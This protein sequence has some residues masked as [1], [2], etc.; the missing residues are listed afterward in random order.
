VEI[1]RLDENGHPLPVQRESI[2]ADTLALGYGF[3][4]ATQL[5]R[6]LGCEHEFAP[7]RGGWIPVRDA[8]MQ[9]TLPGVFAVGDGAGIGGV[10]LARLEGQKAGMQ[11]AHQLGHIDGQAL[12]SLASELRPRLKRE[13]RFADL[14]GD[15]FT[16]GPGLY[17]LGDEG[18]IICRCEEVR[19]ADVR[20]AQAAGCSTLAEIKGLTRVG[21]GNCQGRICGELLAHALLDG[22]SS[23]QE[24]EQKLR[25]LGMFSVRPPIHPLSL[26]DLAQ[27]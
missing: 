25:N 19:L 24:Q 12:Q 9:T 4:P 13:R 16:P 2:V 3:L 17:T 11:A 8:W 5:T 22:D 20:Q 1:A 15:L 21:M 27:R 14:M 10:A 6:L 18:T 26:Q 23:Q 7:R